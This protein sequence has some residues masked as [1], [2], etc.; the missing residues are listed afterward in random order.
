[1]G[2]PGPHSARCLS[3]KG[4]RIRRRMPFAL[5]G[6]SGVQHLFKHTLGQRNSA[7]AAALIK[8]TALFQQ[9]HW[10]R[11]GVFLYINPETEKWEGC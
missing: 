10:N 2:P 7:R 9:T 4:Q 5:T 8:G 1:M 11:K 3:Q 6:S